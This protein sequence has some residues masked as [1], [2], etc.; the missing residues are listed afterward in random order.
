MN[1]RTRTS[2]TALTL[3]L[4]FASTPA[5]AQEAGWLVGLGFGYQKSDD[6]C[7]AAAT[8]VVPCDD[9]GTTWKIFGGY[10]F[11]KFFGL[12][13]GYVDLGKAEASGSITDPVFGTFSG[14]AEFETWGVFFSAVGT[15]PIGQ[16]FGI[17]GK[18]GAAYTDS[19]ATLTGTSSLLGSG[20]LSESDNGTDL[21][22]GV[23]ANFNIQNFSIRVE[24][25]RF[26]NAGGDFEADVDL[27]SA[28]FSYKF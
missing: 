13:G 7:P 25:E 10:Q 3:T 1:R 12:E 26:Q 19:E 11:N 24:W 2:L 20:T 18:V 28:G 15:L 4:A 9:K 5:R 14:T 16:S 23:G 21:T 8:A 17:F 22:Y 27:I 6:N